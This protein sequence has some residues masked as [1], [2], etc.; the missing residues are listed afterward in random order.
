MGRWLRTLHHL[1]LPCRDRSSEGPHQPNDQRAVGGHQGRE[2]SRVEQEARRVRSPQAGS[3]EAMLCSSN[4]GSAREGHRV[5]AVG[6]GRAA[7]LDSDENCQG[8]ARDSS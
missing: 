4:A 8:C 1:R 5:D 7:E 2:R 6:L 3:G